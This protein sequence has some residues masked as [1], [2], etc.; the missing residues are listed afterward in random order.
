MPY[1]TR[2]SNQTVLKDGVYVW[3]EEGPEH[4]PYSSKTAALRAWK[5][6]FC[7]P[8]DEARAAMA[9][10]NARHHLTG[11]SEPWFEAQE[12]H[13]VYKTGWYCWCIEGGYRPAGPFPSEA[14]AQAAWQKYL[15]Q[16]EDEDDVREAMAAAYDE[17]DDG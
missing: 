10:Y 5:A 11:F 13:P 17:E 9:A 12:D 16:Y 4:G 14:A 15:D 6:D 3:G 7:G 8:A 1:I 2:E